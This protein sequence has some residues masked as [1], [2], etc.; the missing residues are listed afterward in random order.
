[1]G[2]YLEYR[3]PDYPSVIP[4]DPP[5]LE[6]KNANTLLMQGTM[7]PMGL[8]VT[9]PDTFYTVTQA[10]SDI[11]LTDV[12]NTAAGNELRF[13]KELSSQAGY[14]AEK[15][16]TAFNQTENRV[17]YPTTPL[18]Q[19][20]AL[21][22]RLIGG[23][24]STPVYSVG[25]DGFDTHANQ[26]RDHPTLL[27]TLSETIATFLKDIE[28]LDV[29]NRVVIAITSEFGR[30][31]EFNGSGTDHGTAAP[32][33]LFGAPINGGFY[34]EQ[35][36]LTDVDESG[37]MKHTIDF[38]QIYAAILEQWMG[39]HSLDSAV[40]LEGEFEPLPLF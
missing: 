2:R 31:V 30:R 22:A 11:P 8:A 3:Y 15:I 18:A 23:G 27:R 1:M 9:N 5:G 40:L 32:L 14:Y 34:G 21:I 37:N 6:I 19:H 38:R 33:F 7:N 39:L 26:L 16:Y 12:P 35:P 29:A 36:S 10:L 24:L 20:F 28:E 25:L 4:D 17:E 13:L